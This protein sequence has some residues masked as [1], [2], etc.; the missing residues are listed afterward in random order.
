MKACRGYEGKAPL[1]L[2]L[3]TRKMRTV[4]FKLQHLWSWGD[5]QLDLLD[6]RL[7]FC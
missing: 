5:S 6:K 7:D 1:I 2:Y 3:V 4:S